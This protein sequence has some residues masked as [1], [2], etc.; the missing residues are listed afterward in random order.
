M[1]PPT[2][3]ERC[4]GASGHGATSVPVADGAAMLFE[5]TLLLIVT[6]AP[7]VQVAFA[8]I[9]IP[10]PAAR[11][12]PV[13]KLEVVS[14]PVIVRPTIETVGS[15]AAWKTPIVRTGP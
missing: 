13:P 4:V 15:D 2:A 3:S 5:M 1:P 8:G 7:P 9:W 6:I 10:P 14:P 11:D 12:P